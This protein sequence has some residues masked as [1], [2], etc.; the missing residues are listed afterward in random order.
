MSLEPVEG[1][2][3]MKRFRK[4]ESIQQLTNG[5]GK[6]CQAFNLDR[7]L[8]G[9]D[10]GSSNLFI[11]NGDKISKSQILK[12]QRVGIKVGVERPWRFLIKGNRFV[13]KR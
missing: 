9:E 12:S 13:S 7:T 5:P 4:T 11:M 8:N 6:L 3:Q 1:L 2:E 10:L